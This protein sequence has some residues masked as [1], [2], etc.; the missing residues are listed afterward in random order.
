MTVVVLD[1][2]VRATTVQ[3]GVALRRHVVQTKTAL[4]H[5]LTL[6]VVELRASRAVARNVPFLLAMEAY[7]R[8]SLNT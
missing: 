2:P 6:I 4:T 3:V 7:H 5:N 1:A 8:S